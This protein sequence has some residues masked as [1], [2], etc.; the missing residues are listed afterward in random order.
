LP[1]RS[2]IVV[3]SRATRLPEMDVSGIAPVASRLFPALLLV[4]QLLRL[5]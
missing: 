3:S 2:I 4:A 5:A 1:R